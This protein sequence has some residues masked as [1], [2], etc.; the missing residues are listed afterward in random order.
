MGM[1]KIVSSEKKIA[2]KEHHCN[3]CGKKISV[4][5]NYRKVV[6]FNNGDRYITKA[7]LDCD[8]EISG[9]IA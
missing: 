2:H 5:S 3:K 7:C 6:Y 4:G 8:V 1:T 9:T